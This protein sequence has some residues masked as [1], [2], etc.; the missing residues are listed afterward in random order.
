MENISENPMEPLLREPKEIKE[1]IA[2][3]LRLEAEKLYL[4]RPHINDDI[5]RIVKEVIK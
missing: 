2:K 5:L 3:V 4:D 1:L